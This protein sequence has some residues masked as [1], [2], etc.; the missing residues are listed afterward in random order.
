MILKRVKEEFK[1]GL[2]YGW[3]RSWQ[4]RWKRCEG[5]MF[6]GGSSLI[7]MGDCGGFICLN[8][9]GIEKI[10]NKYLYE[11]YSSLLY[12]LAVQTFP[13]LLD[14]RFHFLSVQMAA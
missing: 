2:D 6:G 9:N 5:L 4:K 10:I 14:E 7:S 3:L 12:L 13:H 11:I 8:G 1:D